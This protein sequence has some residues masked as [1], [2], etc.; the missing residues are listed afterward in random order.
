MMNLTAA[1]LAAA[2]GAAVF[3]A[4]ERLPAYNQALPL[5]KIDT[6]LRLACFL[7]NVGHEC[8]GF[9]Y[10][11]EIWGPTAAQRRYEGRADLGNIYPGDGELFKGHGDIQ[12]TGRSNH[13]AARDRLRKRF[14]LLQVPDFE[15]NPE[16][17]SEP[18]W[19]ALAA[20]DFWDRN[21]INR[22]A[23]VAN[24]DACCDAVNRGKATLEP[25]DSNG[26]DHRLKLFVAGM[27]VLP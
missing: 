4:Q 16:L 26:F 7:A 3:T 12:I 21:A 10:V 1:Q 18:Q 14:P 8:G 20:C 11:E 15:A 24:F 22:W 13:A 27:R 23:D 6:R 5:F 17:L 19:A 9:R 2:T 25:G